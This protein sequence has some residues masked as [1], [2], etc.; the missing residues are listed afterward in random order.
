MKKQNSYH[1]H[2]KNLEEELMKLK[3]YKQKLESVTEL[4]EVFLNDEL[5]EKKEFARIILEVLGI[6][7][8]DVK[9]K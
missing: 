3:T 2:L 5:T 1:S 6:S 8:K 9:E 4:I 7:E